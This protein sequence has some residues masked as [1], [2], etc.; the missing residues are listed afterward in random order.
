MAMVERVRG[1]AT[2]T[3]DRWAGAGGGHRVTVE[4]E[5]KG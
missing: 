3:R 5:G 4:E 2:G 1:G